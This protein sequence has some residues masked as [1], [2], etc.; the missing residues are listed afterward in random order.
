[1]LTTIPTAEAMTLQTNMMTAARDPAVYALVMIC[2]L[3]LVIILMIQRGTQLMQ[4]RP[5]TKRRPSPPPLPTPL[6]KRQ[7]PPSHAERAEIKAAARKEL[8]KQKREE[9][10]ATQERRNARKAKVES[11][12]ADK[13]PVGVCSMPMEYT[14]E[15]WF[16]DEQ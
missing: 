2:A 16:S 5:A 6:P 8:R 1:M 4:Q 13:L 11:A 3:T 14:E 7:Y 10:T 9:R 15:A 12:L